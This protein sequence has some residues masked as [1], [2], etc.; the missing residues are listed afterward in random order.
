VSFWKNLLDGGEPYNILVFAKDGSVLA[1]EAKVF[2]QRRMSVRVL[3][4]LKTVEEALRKDDITLLLIDAESYDKQSAEIIF[5]LRRQFPKVQIGAVGE[6]EDARKDAVIAAGANLT[7]TGS[8]SSNRK[9][10]QKECKNVRNRDP[11]IEQKQDVAPKRSPARKGE[12]IRIGSTAFATKSKVLDVRKPEHVLSRSG[13]QRSVILPVE[14][15]LPVSQRKTLVPVCPESK[16]KFVHDLSVPKTQCHELYRDPAIADQSE[17]PEDTSGIVAPPSAVIDALAVS[18]PMVSDPRDTSEKMEHPLLLIDAFAV[19]TPMIGHP[20]D[21]SEKMGLPGPV[22]DAF[23]VSTP[24]IGHPEDMS[25]K[26]GLPGPVL[27]AFAVSMPMIGHPEDTSENAS[28]PS[29]VIDALGVSLPVFSGDFVHNNGIDDLSGLISPTV[30]EGCAIRM[31]STTSGTNAR[32]SLQYSSFD[33]K[34]PEPLK[35]EKLISLDFE[36]GENAVARGKPVIREP[37]KLDLNDFSIPQPKHP[38]LDLPSTD[39]LITEFL[40]PKSKFVSDTEEIEESSAEKSVSKTDLEKDDPPDDKTLVESKDEQSPDEMDIPEDSPAAEEHSKP[41]SDL[42]EEVIPLPPK[43][44]VSAMPEPPMPPPP[45]KPTAPSVEEEAAEEI[46]AP[47]SAERPP[48]PLPTTV[49]P[50]VPLPPKPPVSVM[51]AKPPIPPPPP[52]QVAP[53]AEKAAIA[54]EI[55]KPPKPLPTTV[56][57]VVTLSPK[58]PVYVMPAKPSMPPPPPKPGATP[59]KK[60]AAANEISEPPKPVLPMPKPWNEP[61]GA[62]A[63][64]RLAERSG[65]DAN[66]EEKPAPPSAEGPNPLPTTVMPA[67]SP[68]PPSPP[69]PPAPAVAKTAIANE[70]PP[71]PLKEDPPKVALKPWGDPVAQAPVP[72]DASGAVPAEGKP[73][74]LPVSG[75]PM[76]SGLPKPPGVPVKTAKSPTPPAPPKL[77]TP[78][79]Q[80]VEAGKRPGLPQPAAYKIASAPPA[81]K[82]QKTEAPK[83]ASA[84]EALIAWRSIQVKNSEA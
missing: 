72:M 67:K 6:L 22:L 70:M 51:P 14:P 62:S 56:K 36:I 63:S 49:K 21:M 82:K 7:L 11:N 44:P 66:A 84:N 8:F 81:P 48:K 42:T 2:G 64:S 53:P 29:P 18:T 78:R 28:L 35:G 23:A 60:A 25:E 41:S 47:P 57:P 3:F 4:D 58:P 43:P 55:S 54:N 1:R 31:A 71:P 16:Q 30:T 10:I 15:T 79:T 50:V 80:P 77:M 46:P 65:D 5:Y 73:K 76:D 33:I 20:K 32:Q 75:K 13:K 19:S 17:T 69:K 59:A 40:P 34:C 68:M 39:Q 74:P 45:P 83:F 12:S 27:D 24:M 9:I 38:V 61:V 52:K 26:M 37:E